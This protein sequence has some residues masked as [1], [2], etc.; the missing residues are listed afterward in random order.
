MNNLAAKYD[1][2]GRHEDA[3]VLFQKTLEIRQRVLPRND[4]QIGMN[5]LFFHACK[6]KHQLY[7]LQAMQ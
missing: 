2:L 1:E 3:L 5:K 7:I 6:A 4:P